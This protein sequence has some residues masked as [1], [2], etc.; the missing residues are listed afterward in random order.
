MERWFLTRRFWRLREC[1]FN[2]LSKN[3]PG[4][5]RIWRDTRLEGGL[6]SRWPNYYAL[7]DTLWRR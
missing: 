3:I 5:R 1:I 2:M 7:L 6:H 4:S